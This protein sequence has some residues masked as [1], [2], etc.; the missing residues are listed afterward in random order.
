M[1]GESNAIIAYRH[2]I[3]ITKHGNINLFYFGD[4]VMLI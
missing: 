2:F 4:K 1:Q 3:S